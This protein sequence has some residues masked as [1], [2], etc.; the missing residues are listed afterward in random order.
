[1][2]LIKVWL[3]WEVR[4]RWIPTFV[5]LITLQGGFL[6]KIRITGLHYGNGIFS[7]KSKLVSES[8]AECSKIKRF[9]KAEGRHFL[10]WWQFAYFSNA[11]ILLKICLSSKNLAPFL[12]TLQTKTE[13]PLFWGYTPPGFH[14]LI[15]DLSALK[16]YCD[17]KAN[18]VVA[19]IKDWESEIREHYQSVSYFY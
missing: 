8:T 15:Q 1:M 5:T 12:I 17:G 9:H 3:Q 14:S 7:F 19:F 18:E 13:R 4:M 2:K 16:A 11:N 6:S 10:S